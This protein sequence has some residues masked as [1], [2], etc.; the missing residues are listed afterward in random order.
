[1]FPFAILSSH[2]PSSGIPYIAKHVNCLITS[3]TCHVLSSY[4]TLYVKKYFI[5]ALIW[6][7]QQP[8]EVKQS[9]LLFMDKEIESQEDWNW[10]VI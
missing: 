4:H 9:F 3:I 2:H 8:L 6:F 7:S 5:Q 1:M 10:T